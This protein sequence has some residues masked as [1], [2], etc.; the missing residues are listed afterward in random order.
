MDKNRVHLLTALVLLF[1]SSVVGAADTDP[2]QQAAEAASKSF[3]QQLG[4]TMKSEMQSNGP[5]AAVKVC[6]ET[7]P[8]MTG[9]ISRNN[10]WKVTR[11]GTRVRNPM[12]GMPD[13]WEQTVLAQ[14]QQRADK[15]ESFQSMSFSEIVD[16]PDGQ[17]FRYMKAIGVKPLCLT[18]HGGENDI[19]E[20][21][22]TV[23]QQRYPYDEATGYAAGDLRG[24]VSIK[25]PVGKM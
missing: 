9:E 14:F 15:G 4:K 2:Y 13:V 11:V 20:A 1:G 8:N 10:G 19:P 3:L 21:V 24:A 23:L 5:V 25:H 6:S 7:A 22:R 12:L 17:Y 16:E 18:C